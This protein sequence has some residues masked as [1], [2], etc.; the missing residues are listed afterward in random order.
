MLAAYE[1]QDLPFEQVVGAVIKN[2]EEDKDLLQQ[3]VFGLEKIPDIAA[4]R[5][6]SLQVSRE[7]GSSYHCRGDESFRA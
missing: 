7:D 4:L 1:H 5:L 6:G 3:V 2:R